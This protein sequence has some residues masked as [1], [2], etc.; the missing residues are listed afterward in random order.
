MGSVITAVLEH[1]FHNN[2]A[3][4]YPSEDKNG[5][6][7]SI[8]VAFYISVYYA[9]DHVLAFGTCADQLSSIFRYDRQNMKN[10]VATTIP[11]CHV[12]EPNYVTK[13]RF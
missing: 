9:S 8:L 3:D 4:W 11:N 5:T 12:S 6:Q 13:L 10:E 1:D 2:L 7:K